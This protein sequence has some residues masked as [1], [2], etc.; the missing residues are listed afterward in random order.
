MQ[1]I[2]SLLTTD[3]FR[4]FNYLHCAIYSTRKRKKQQKI[5]SSY[6]VGCES[7][8]RI[9]LIKTNRNKSLGLYGS[10]FK[11]GLSIACS[12]TPRNVLELY[13]S[14]VLDIRVFDI[15]ITKLFCSHFEEIS[16]EQL[17]GLIKTVMLCADHNFTFKRD[18]CL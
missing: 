4:K 16:N 14:T 17:H 9:I 5:F 11:I 13:Y 1:N 18:F 6:D 3:F 8:E 7:P 10:Q 12:C 15:K 2:N